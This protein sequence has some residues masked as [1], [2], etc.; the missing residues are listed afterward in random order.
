MLSSHEQERTQLI[1]EVDSHIR[2]ISEEK[3]INKFLQENVQLSRNEN[4]DLGQQIDKEKKA[5]K[6]LREDVEQLEE[7]KTALS[8]IDGIVDQFGHC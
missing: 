7:M 5:N 1:N 2:Q 3:E 8:R 6:L 4:I